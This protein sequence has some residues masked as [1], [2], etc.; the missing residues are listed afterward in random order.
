MLLDSRCPSLAP[1][2]AVRGARGGRRERGERRGPG[3][4]A[5][6]GDRARA[7]HDLGPAPALQPTPFRHAGAL[8]G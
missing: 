1:L 3:E 2:C 6:G 8:L 4:E 7:E 5:H